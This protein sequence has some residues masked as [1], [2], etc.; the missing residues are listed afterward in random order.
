MK[1][2][3]SLKFCQ[4]C[5]IFT[6]N[7]FHCIFSQ[8]FLSKNVDLGILVPLFPNSEQS[9]GCEKR[10]IPILLRSSCPQVFFKKGVLKNFANF[11]KKETL[12]KVFY[13]EFSQIFKNTFFY[14]S[15][16][17]FW[18]FNALFLLLAFEN[19]PD[20]KIYIS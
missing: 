18:L 6:W 1:N 13:Y 9:Q 15:G 16:G 5:C 19:C 3:S 14:I 7:S 10:T 2:N 12:A 17:C 4:T 8:D 11:I 20:S